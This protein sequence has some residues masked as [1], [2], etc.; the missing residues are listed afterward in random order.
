M[1]LDLHN[2]DVGGKAQFEKV[3]LTDHVNFIPFGSIIYSFFI[4][5]N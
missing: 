2:S 4:I 1:N 3:Y 5:K